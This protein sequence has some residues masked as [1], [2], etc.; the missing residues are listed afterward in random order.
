MASPTNVASP[1]DDMKKTG[2]D[3]KNE[4]NSHF[5]KRRF[6]EALACYSEGIAVV[7]TTQAE[8]DLEVT[9]Y[10]NR[11]GCYYEMGDYGK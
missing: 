10:S 5:M 9:L 4:G 3:L 2:L 6:T 8:D 11:S 7:T 1:T